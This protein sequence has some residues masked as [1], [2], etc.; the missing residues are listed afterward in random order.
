MSLYDYLTPTEMNSFLVNDMMDK[1]GADREEAKVFEV[2]KRVNNCD[3]TITKNTDFLRFCNFDIAIYYS[4]TDVVKF[5]ES[6]FTTKE[7]LLMF[8]ETDYHGYRN[9]ITSE[10]VTDEYLQKVVLKMV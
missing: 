7:K 5:V 10:L 2:V 4:F 8:S 9:W 1:S 6:C 3:I